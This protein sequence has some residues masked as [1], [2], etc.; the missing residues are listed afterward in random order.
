[1]GS[2][3]KIAFLLLIRIKNHLFFTV[4]CMGGVY[5][6]CGFVVFVAVAFVFPRVRGGHI[7]EWTYFFNLEY[8]KGLGQH[9]LDCC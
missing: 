9:F 3:A 7:V 2:T 1:M 8:D 4:S 6:F 5:F